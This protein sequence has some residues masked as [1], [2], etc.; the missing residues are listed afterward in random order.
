MNTS[1]FPCNDLVFYHE[2]KMLSKFKVTSG[3]PIWDV[4]S[5]LTFYTRVLYSE[6]DWIMD[7]YTIT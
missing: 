6:I 1:K 2:E 5:T 3:I 4:T 7:M